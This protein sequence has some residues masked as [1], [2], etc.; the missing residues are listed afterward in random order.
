[1]DSLNSGEKNVP[2]LCRSNRAGLGPCTL[3][4]TADLQMNLYYTD[5]LPNIS[6]W[7]DHL[8]ELVKRVEGLVQRQQTLLV[9]IQMLQHRHVIFLKKEITIVGS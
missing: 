7:F 6:T 3:H 1:M 8:T 4:F 9:S 2:Q 5:H